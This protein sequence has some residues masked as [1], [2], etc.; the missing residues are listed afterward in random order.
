[1][2]KNLK[3]GFLAPRN[4]WD[5]IKFHSTFLFLEKHLLEFFV[6]KALKIILYW[7]EPEWKKISGAEIGLLSVGYLEM[8]IPVRI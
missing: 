2:A 3:V 6:S 7:F 1:M 8:L 5:N 4:S